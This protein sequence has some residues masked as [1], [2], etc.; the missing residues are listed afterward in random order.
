MLFDSFQ[1]IDAVMAAL[2]AQPV[3]DVPHPVYAVDGFL[4]GHVRDYVMGAADGEFVATSLILPKTGN[5]VVAWRRQAN[6]LIAAHADASAVFI[7]HNDMPLNQREA[8]CLLINPGADALVGALGRMVPIPLTDADRSTL[9]RALQIKKRRAQ[10]RAGRD[11]EV[12]A[13]FGGISEYLHTEAP[14]AY[15]IQ[16]SDVHGLM[17]DFVSNTNEDGQYVAPDAPAPAQEEEDDDA[18]L[19]LGIA[20]SLVEE[21]PEP[22]ARPL[23]RTCQEVLDADIPDLATAGQPVC[24]ACQKHRASICF[25]SCGHQSMCGPCLRQWLEASPHCPMCR[26]TNIDVI[27][28]FWSE[29]EK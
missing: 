3:E 1:R 29:P 14:P 28:P 27:R 26:N 10:S 13:V 17:H 25:V 15:H 21:Q 20:A 8:P 4:A 22:P 19:Q 2:G 18:Q 7:F 5:S 24:I 23:K 12:R 16:A 11:A 6:H 9:G